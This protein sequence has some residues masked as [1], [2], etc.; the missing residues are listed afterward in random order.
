MFQSKKSRRNGALERAKSYTWQNSK[1]FRLAVKRGVTEFGTLQSKWE[2]NN[3]EHI[4]HLAK[5]V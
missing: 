5:M 1:A 2:A 4:K 3:A